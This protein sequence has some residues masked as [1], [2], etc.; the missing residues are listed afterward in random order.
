MVAGGAL[1]RQHRGEVRGR[2]GLARNLL[3]LRSAGNGGSVTLAHGP[4]LPVPRRGYCTSIVP[5]MLGWMA[6]KYSIVPA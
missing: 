4:S 2:L 5:V 3:G 6:Q 1:E